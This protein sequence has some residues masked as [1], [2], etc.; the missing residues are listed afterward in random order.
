MNNETERTAFEA[1]YRD[2]YGHD[3]RTELHRDPVEFGGTGEYTRTFTHVHFEVWKA[4]AALPT[5]CVEVVA[6]LAEDSEGN[7]GLSFKENFAM[8]ECEPG[9]T[10]TPL[11]RA[12]HRPEPAKPDSGKGE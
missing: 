12:T 10:V 3:C 9:A 4:R 1:F 8:R 5:T 2:Y 6:Y 7:R 11:I